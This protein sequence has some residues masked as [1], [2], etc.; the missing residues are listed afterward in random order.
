MEARIENNSGLQLIIPKD[1]KAP[2]LY[3][4]WLSE[5]NILYFQ[6]M[7]INDTAGIKQGYFRIRLLA[8][9]EFYENAK[10]YIN[11]NL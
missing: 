1:G 7:V 6:E 2:M 11:Q 3:L 9:R 8:T 5:Q 4:E 10:E